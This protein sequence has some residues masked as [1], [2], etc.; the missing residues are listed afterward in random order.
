MENIHGN[1]RKQWSLY[2]LAKAS[3]MSRAG[4]SVHFKKKVGLTPGEYIAHWR[5]QVACG[6]LE[7]GEQNISSVAEEVGY[8]SQSAFSTA[9]NR[10]VGRRP[11]SYRKSLISEEQRWPK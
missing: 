11:G 8:D 10:I 9:F 1:V 2:E 5:M 7:S 3:G 4:F 6:L